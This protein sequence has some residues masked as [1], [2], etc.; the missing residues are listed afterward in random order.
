MG[1]HTHGQSK[2]G[3][4]Q[5]YIQRDCCGCEEHNLGIQRTKCDG[6]ASRQNTPKYTPEGLQ[7]TRLSL[8]VQCSLVL[9]N[10]PV[11]HLLPTGKP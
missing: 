6:I 9:S 3:L 8:C 4:L 10:T 11:F 1:F 2:V 5:S 7:G